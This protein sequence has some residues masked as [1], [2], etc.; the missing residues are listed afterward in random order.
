MLAILHICKYAKHE[1]IQF[2]IML[3]PQQIQLLFALRSAVKARNIGLR[4]ISDATGVHVSQVSRILAGH[5]KRASP[6]VE[7]ICNFAKLG[8]LQQSS[9]SNE[10]L[11]RVAVNSL[12]DGTP[13]HALALSNLLGAINSY[14]TSIRNSAFKS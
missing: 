1:V 5:V 8:Q 12:W 2:T 3:N 4:Q 11:L 13:E 14:Q 9:T 6:N 10:D 7:K